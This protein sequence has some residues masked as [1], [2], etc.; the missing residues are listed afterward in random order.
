MT[1]AEPLETPWMLTGYSEPIIATCALTLGDP[2]VNVFARDDGELL[3]TATIDTPDADSSFTTSSGV[4]VTFDWYERSTGLAT[5]TQ[6]PFSRD[7]TRIYGF[8]ETADGQQLPA[9]VRFEEGGLQ[10]IVVLE[11]PTEQEGFSSNVSSMVRHIEQAPDGTVWWI[12]QDDSGTEL[13]SSAGAKYPFTS[14]GG[15]GFYDLAFGSGGEVAIAYVSQAGTLDAFQLVPDFTAQ[16]GT[17]PF[18]DESQDAAVFRN[19]D[20]IAILPE[21]EYDVL[22]GMETDDGQVIFLAIEPGLEVP[23]LWTVPAS[24]GEPS[25]IIEEVAAAPTDAPFGLGWVYYVGSPLEESQ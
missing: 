2:T 21:T 1:T 10:Q 12:R 16:E 24:G 14:P 5:C 3:F 25:P 4:D 23:G 8:A 13:R 18:H 11:E 17:L 7:L 20:L 19:E 9:Y 22:N 15:G 6:K